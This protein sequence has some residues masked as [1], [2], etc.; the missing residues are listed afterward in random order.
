MNEAI[1]QSSIFASYKRPKN[2]KDLLIHSRFNSASNSVTNV[3]CHI[4]DDCFL[5][6]YFLIDTDTFKSYEC[7]TKFKIK[8]NLDCSTEGIIYLL[9]DLICKRSYTGSTIYAMNP[10]MSNYK[11]HIKTQ[12]KDCEMAQHF[13]ACG[14][15]IHPF[16]GT[17]AVAGSRSKLNRHNENVNLSKQIKVIIIEKVDL[18]SVKTTKEKRNLIEIREGFWQ[19]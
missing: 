10:R 3:G 18:S 12:H 19:T 13:A 17:D 2:I 4:K 16:L 11:N 15:D 1:P 9:L 8:D 7:D 6:K 14:P 5:C